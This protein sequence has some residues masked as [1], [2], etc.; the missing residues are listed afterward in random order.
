[1]LKLGRVVVL[2]ASAGGHEAVARVLE[3][4]GAESPH[5]FVVAIKASESPSML[6]ETLEPRTSLKIVCVEDPVPLLPGTVYL[7][8]AGS[9]LVVTQ[10]EVSVVSR[11][12]GASGLE[13]L[14]EGV[15][16]A[17]G[18]RAT[19]VVLSGGAAPIRAG[20]QQILDVGGT[21]YCQSPSTAALEE[22]PVS[23]LREVGASGVGSVEEIAAWIRDGLSPEVRD[24]GDPER[25]DVPLPAAFWTL[26]EALR[27]EMSLDLYAYRTAT[28]YRRVMQ[29]SRARGCEDIEGYI[30]QAL[31]E[32]DEL[33]TLASRLL[34]GT[35]DFYRNEA[36]FDDLREIVVP[37]VKDQPTFSVWCAG[38]ST[39][40]EP[41]SVAAT[42]LAEL[43]AAGSSTRLRVLATDV[44]PEAID[45]ASL[46]V[47]PA[48]RVAN[49]P[50]GLR[51]LYGYERDG[52][53]HAGEAL[54]DCVR[55]AVHDV[56]SDPPPENRDLVLFRN[57]LIYLRPEVHPRALTRMHEALRPGGFLAVAESESTHSLE[58]AFARHAPQGAILQRVERRTR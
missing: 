9:R 30:D 48:E 29:R 35:T 11:A 2:V 42:L 32:P 54:R 39:G 17:W 16:D 49:M 22:M 5:A 33:R 38:C 15:A 40:E 57:V 24:T 28:L 14:L 10:T 26:L 4:V 3:R 44:R 6:P 45:R 27:V 13:G 7:A 23:V 46:G 8:S 43:E 50:S 47:Y 21:L 53:W 52:E 37:A 20:A 58:G 51:S 31:R 56:L 36:L 25:C 12:A 41:W 18:D 55:F 34:I 1:M 19:V